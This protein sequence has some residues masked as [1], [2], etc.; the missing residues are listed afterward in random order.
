M[1]S[2]EQRKDF[3]F[4]AIGASAGAVT[5]LKTVLERLPGVS[6]VPIA[7]VVHL[8]ADNPSLLPEL[9]RKCVD[10]PVREPEDKEPIE[11]NCLYIA[12]PNYHLLVE[13]ERVFC[14][15]LDDPV[16]YSIPSI[17]VFF[18]SVASSFGPR[19]VGVVLTGANNDGADGL[20]LIS[21]AGGVC[22][23]QDPSSAHV[24]TMPQA[25]IQAV[26]TAN[27]LTLQEIGDFLSA[28]MNR[29]L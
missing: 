25:A 18:Q 14:L 21:E 4:I 8:P 13:K 3:D 17:D 7:I 5:A 29:K 28:V 1:S 24:P 9:F 11:K 15:N 20:R 6:Q 23:V 19:C 12:P 16:K 10:L 2:T 26:P 22:V 27:I